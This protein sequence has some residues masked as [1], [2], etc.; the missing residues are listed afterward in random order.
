MCN[1]PGVFWLPAVG[2]LAGTSGVPP[3]ENRRP[4]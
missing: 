3:D 2:R 4:V 1:L